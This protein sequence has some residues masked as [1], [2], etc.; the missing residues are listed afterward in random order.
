MSK[1]PLDKIQKLLEYNIPIKL[2]DKIPEKWEKI[3]NI[4]IIKLPSELYK[5]K[6]AIGKVYAQV[7]DCKTVLNDISG[8]TGEYRVPHVEILY[9]KKDT[10]TI[11]K[12]N[13][14]IYRLDP[15]KIMFSSGNMDERIRMATIS[16]KK[17]TVVDLF[18]GIGYFTLPIA[19]Y[20]KPKKIYACEKNP[21][22]FNYLKQNITLNN[23]NSIVEP[24][25]GDN[26]KIAPKNVADRVIMGYFGKTNEFIS[27]AINC[28]KNNCGIIHY[29]DKF[30]QENIPDKPLE[31]IKDSA[32]K[33]NKQ[34]KLLQYKQIK[35]YA[36]GINHYVFDI[37]LVEK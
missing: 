7:L 23:V 30:P 36:P 8:I 4:A 21:V 26:R 6:S 27:T 33:F 20:S 1:T 2:S 10:E 22:A 18:A 3:G 31:I 37:K 16:N 5:Y 15:Q 24:L 35:K 17:E 32:N 28:L 13:K 9:G 11:H 29:H 34:I 19:V 25:K 14:I 12:E